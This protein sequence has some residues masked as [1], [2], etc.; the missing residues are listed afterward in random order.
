[1][2]FTTLIMPIAVASCSKVGQL[3]PPSIAVTQVA[4]LK[5]KAKAPDCSMPVLN[6]TPT[7]F[8]T[9]AI[10]EGQGL[11]EQ[12]NEMLTIMR[13]K[14]CEMDADALLILSDQG[15]LAPGTSHYA[16]QNSAGG[17]AGQPSGYKGNVAKNC[18]GGH[19]GCFIDAYAIVRVMPH[20][21][22]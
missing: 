6:V 4:P 10:I 16:D 13:Q 20:E 12:R 8:R 1:M 2:R 21:E 22:K 17:V 9:V 19:S 14:A 11:A 5:S 7:S 18:E 15:F 3:A